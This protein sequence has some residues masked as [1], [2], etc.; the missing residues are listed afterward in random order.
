AP[1]D[2]S[3]D[4]LSFRWAKNLKLRNVEIGWEAPAYAPWRSALRIRDVLG[5]ELDDVAAGRAPVETAAGAAAI[6]LEGV[7][8]AVVRNGR[9]AAG[10]GTYVAVD[11][12]ASDNIV[13]IGN[14]IRNAAKPFVS[15]PQVKPGAMRILTNIN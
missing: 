12:P 6:V 14:D 2:T 3:V 9:S 11:G 15:G 10:T 1:Y 8:D 13:F 5:L 4:A 7:R